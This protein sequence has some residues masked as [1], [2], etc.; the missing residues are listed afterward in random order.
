MYELYNN[1]NLSKIIELYRHDKARVNI[2]L[3]PFQTI[4]HQSLLIYESNLTDFNLFS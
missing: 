4:I 1:Y 3:R 2:D